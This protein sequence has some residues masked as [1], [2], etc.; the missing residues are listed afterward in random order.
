MNKY[1]V[2]G[3]VGEGAYGV[4]LKCRNKDTGNVLAIKKFKESEDDEI[5]RKT[6]RHIAWGEEVLD[7]LC[8][9]DAK[10]QRRHTRQRKLQ[11]QLKKSGGVTGDLGQDH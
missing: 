6:K 1:E 9:T 11:E 10:R 7:R 8:D 3:V 5:V 4:V 2:L